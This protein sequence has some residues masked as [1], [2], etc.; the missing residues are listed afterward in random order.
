[1]KS[2]LKLRTAA[3][4]A[5]FI[6]LAACGGGG[7]NT[8]DTNETSNLSVTSDKKSLSFTGFVAGGVVSQAIQFTLSQASGTYY[9]QAVFD[10]PDLFAEPSIVFN[11]DN[12]ATVSITAIDV[13]ADHNG[14]VID[15]KLCRDPVCGDE[16]WSTSIPYTRNLYEISNSGVSIAIFEGDGR[17]EV[18]IPV[19]PM[20][21]EGSLSVSVI[22]D[23]VTV[24]PWLEATV[25]SDAIVVSAGSADMPAGYY[26]GVVQLGVADHPEL[27]TYDIPAGL[28]VEARVAAAKPRI[29]E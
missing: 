25:A 9:A 20:V 12:S 14:G 6:V 27:G 26:S 3:V 1:M 15:F 10:R 29:A 21:A 2:L 23:D 11:G 5:C 19:T 28:S 4:C 13:A 17:Q 22:Q 18:R 7:G 8:G 16:V 24:M